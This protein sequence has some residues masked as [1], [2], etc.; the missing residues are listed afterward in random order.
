MDTDPRLSDADRAAL[1][2]RQ[3]AAFVGVTLFKDG[4]MVAAFG[5][6]HD[7]PRAW[8]PTEIELVRD[9]AERTWDAVER[10]RAESALREQNTRLGLALEASAGGSW[11]WDVRTNDADWDDTFRAQF[12]F[13]PDEPPSFETG[14]HVSTPT[15]ARGCCAP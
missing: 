2:A 14:S 8:T 1:R 15:T 12:E 10:T 4:R 6:N 7:T 3:I 13:T 11:T 5:A 9:V